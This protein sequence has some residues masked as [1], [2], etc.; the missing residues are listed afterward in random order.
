MSRFASCI[1]DARRFAALL[2]DDVLR[3]LR[4]VEELGIA[5]RCDVV[6]ADAIKYLERSDDRFGL[7]FCDAPYRLANRLEPKLEEHLPQRLA[8][9]ARLVLES[10]ARDPLTIDV[11]KVELVDTRRIGEALIQIYVKR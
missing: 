9:H 8:K 3:P 4:N 2:E 7:V 10:S 11:P 6:R 1:H 5:N